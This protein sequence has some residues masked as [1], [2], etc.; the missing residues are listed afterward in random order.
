MV[1]LLQ[2]KNP[3]YASF[4]PARESSRFDVKSREIKNEK[5]LSSS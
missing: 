2:L 1:M 3:P 5:L 4:Y